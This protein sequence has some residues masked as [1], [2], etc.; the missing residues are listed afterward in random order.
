MLATIRV[1]DGGFTHARVLVTILDCTIVLRRA[2]DPR[3]PLKCTALMEIKGVSIR[4]AFF[5]ISEFHMRS[6]LFDTFGVHTQQSHCLRCTKDVSD[7][8]KPLW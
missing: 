6:E 2:A 3:A 4:S 1:V 7:A 5:C 8:M